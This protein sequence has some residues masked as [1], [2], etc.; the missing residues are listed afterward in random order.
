MLQIIWFKKCHR[1]V[2]DI[3]SVFTSRLIVWSGCSRDKRRAGW[4]SGWRLVE[5]WASVGLQRSSGVRRGVRK[6]GAMT[7]LYPQSFAPA[8][9]CVASLCGECSCP[10]ALTEKLIEK[11]W[12]TSTTRHSTITVLLWSCRLSLFLLIFICFY[13]S[14]CLIAL[15]EFCTLALKFVC[16]SCWSAH[17][18]R[19]WSLC[20]WIRL[21]CR[22]F[23]LFLRTRMHDERLCC[24]SFCVSL[25]VFLIS[26]M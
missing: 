2:T 6:H 20:V 1:H 26:H 11:H 12:T 18:G 17:S 10:P 13:C 24:H 19:R 14:F 4:N 8:L 3:F 5:L 9:H 7:C 16:L 15:S 25:I 22:S 21:S 23:L